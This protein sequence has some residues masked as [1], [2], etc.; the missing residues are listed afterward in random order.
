MPSSSMEESTVRKALT[1]DPG[2]LTLEGRDGRLL[3]ARLLRAENATRGRV[4]T[5]VIERGGL[6]DSDGRFLEVPP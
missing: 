2:Q 3:G 1:V 4:I 5:G 6:Y